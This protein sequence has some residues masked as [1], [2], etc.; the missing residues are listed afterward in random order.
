MDKNS[1]ANFTK[2]ALTGM[3]AGAAIVVVGKMILDSNK[4]LSQGSKRAIKAVGEFVDGV[5]TMFH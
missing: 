3:A 5:Q 4:N 2:G 1:T